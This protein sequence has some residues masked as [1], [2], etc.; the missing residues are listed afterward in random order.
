MQI[1]GDMRRLR[2]SLLPF[3]RNRADGCDTPNIARARSAKRHDP[4][5]T[6]VFGILFFSETGIFTAKV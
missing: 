5:D 6:V 4:G 2:E 1:I 3:A